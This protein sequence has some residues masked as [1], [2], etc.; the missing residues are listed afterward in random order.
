MRILL[1]LAFLLTATAG[2]ALGQVTATPKL[3]LRTAPEAVD[4]TAL[5][6]QRYGRTLDMLKAEFP[7]DYSALTAQFDALDDKVGE[8]DELLLAAFE[9]LTEVRRKY[10]GK[11]QFAPSLSHSV[12]L[13]RIAEFHDLVFKGEGP[14]VCGRFAHDGSAVLFELGLSGKYAE[15]LDLQSLAYFDA[16]VKAI[17]TPE[18]AEPPAAEDWTAMLAAM[19]A[20]GAPPTYLRSVTTGDPKDPDLCPAL[21]AMFRTSGLL[22]TPQAARTRADFARNLSGY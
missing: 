5:V 3:N 19:V 10:A 14:Q 13:G 7:A 4:V 16:V 15:A 6:E 20:A 1:C 22:D 18:Y 17:E 8:R 2:P 9:R 11:L 21:A 12:M